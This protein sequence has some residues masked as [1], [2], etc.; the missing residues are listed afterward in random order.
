[1]LMY[2]TIEPSSYP[3]LILIDRLCDLFK[4]YTYDVEIISL[5]RCYRIGVQHL[6][7]L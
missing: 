6:Y 4:S 7:E 3:N 1:M 2:L 5:V